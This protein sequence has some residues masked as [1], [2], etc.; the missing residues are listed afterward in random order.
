V[1]HN[2]SPQC[3]H[4]VIGARV[5]ATPEAVAVQVG[6]AR[7]TYRQ[8]D[9]R[10]TAI[11]AR[12]CA[13]GAGR[14]AVVAVLA[15][16]T[17]DLV[18]A[19]L[20][21]LKSGAAYLPLDPRQPPAR[22]S[23]C[24][25]DA[26]ASI[27]LTDR[28]LPA[29]MAVGRARVLN[30]ADTRP[31]KAACQVAVSPDDLAYVLYTSGSTGRPK[32]VLVEHRNV[33][34]LMST[35][36]G[37]FEV[38]ASDTV[39]SV[40]AVTF[41]MSVGDIFCTLARRARL[42]LAT[43]EQAM[44]PAELGRLIADTRATYMMATPTTWS[45]LIAEGWNGD[46]NLIA[47]PAGETLTD[48]LAE[49]L[50]QRC[51]AVWN[52]WGPTETTVV[53]AAARLTGGDTVTVGTPLPGV[54]VYVTD[55]RGRIQPVGVPGEIAV[56]GAGVARGYLNLPD[57]H[58]LRF[59]DDPF[60]V[61]GRI[62]RTGDRGRFLPDGRLQHLGRCDEQ[63]KIRGVRIEPGEIESTLCEHPKVSACAVVARQAPDGDKQ[64]V[65]YIVGGPSS[66]QAREWLRR[67]LP[68]HM[69]PAAFV[70]LSVLPVTASGKLDKAALPAPSPRPTGPQ[71]A[72]PPR[73]DTERRVAKL[74][75]DLLGV[76]VTDVNADFF[77]MGGH[78]LLAVRLIAQVQRTS[79]VELPLAA[80]VD[81]GRTIAGLAALLDAE[82]PSDSGEV[83]SAPPLHFIF[84]DRASA[85]SLRQFT[86]QWGS[87]QP[88][89]PL[90]PEQP[91]GLFDQSVTIEA[92]ASQLLSMIRD[93]QPKG[94]LAVAGYSLGGLVAYEIA[95]Q[96]ADA[97]LQINWLGILDALAP[98]MAH[99]ARNQ[100]VR[101]QLTD[102][103]LRGRLNRL[104]QLPARQQWAK[105]VEVALRV[106][107]RGP[108][109]LRPA[110]AL[111]D[112]DQ[113][114]ALEI[115]CRY[116]QPG[117]QVPMHLFVTEGS[118]AE[119]AA[120]LLGWDKFHNGPLAAEHLP[121]DHQTLLKPPDVERLAR[122]ML[123]SLHKARAAVA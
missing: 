16:R 67:R 85:M 33:V 47:V 89:H 11:A 82:T 35:M 109:V 121:G 40:A 59:A 94:P 115:E 88:V 5:E 55:P 43:G 19:L 44:D 104:S 23:Y 103:R 30:L 73:N 71:D 32:G 69:V 111:S 38:T 87:A 118:A 31:S 86:A 51:R 105:Y 66:A 72:Q 122:L 7:L 80:F 112:F 91:G 50:R 27:I 96:A 21:I 83:T 75:A 60:D 84:S 57:E 68:E 63:V 46:P 113:R 1:P 29:D 18:A 24:I 6:E 12:L 99:L 77:D 62:Y 107:R 4:E 36:F 22:N 106:L 48:A 3:I 34:N 92:H 61:G 70:R 15:E 98:P 119:V 78:S 58:A 37:E 65:A 53:A 20:A 49:A 100:L 102:L 95:R 45:A 110:P 117:H 42:V 39:V 10:A 28:H 41:D 90:I 52:A 123:K 81:H 14:G 101:E 9:D 64:L 26:D 8:L 25:T 97:G 17:P 76:P 74:W 2:V 114:G 116:R 56:G 54:R 108:G 120:D 13:A 79:G 93:S